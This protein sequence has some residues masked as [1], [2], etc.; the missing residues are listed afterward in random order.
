M[1]PFAHAGRRHSSSLI[2]AKNAVV[3]QK[4]PA[5]RLSRDTGFL[6]SA[7]AGGVAAAAATVTFHPVD[8]MKTVLQG[9]AGLAAVRALGAKGLYRGV[10]PAAFSMMPA[11]A[12]RM[13]A[14]EVLKGVML[15]HAPGAVP[16]SVS[17]FLA[18]ACS[19]VASVSVRAPLDMIKTKVQSDAT[20]TAM[21]AFR[22]AWGSGGLSG[23]ASLYRGAGLA[24][25]RDVPFFGV[26][27][28]VYEQLKASA[29]ARARAQAAAGCAAGCAGGGRSCSSCARDTARDTAPSRPA[30]AAAT[31]RGGGCMPAADVTL[32]PVDLLVI[33]FAAQ[34]LAGLLTN[35]AD[36]LKTRVQSGAASDMG[37]AVR[38]VWAERGPAS[39]MQ[40]AG[41]RVV[42]IAPQG[43]VYYPAYEFVQRLLAPK[44]S[45]LKAP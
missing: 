40:G 24:L 35:P 33:G 23:F 29:L 18:S 25:V 32:S 19:V 22:A 1:M 6:R 38:A 34:G 16:P 41:M 28:L 37:A 26:N 4:P 3:E 17:V 30:K 11:C 5:Q 44:P 20:V 31:P 39:L 13:G 10:L 45:E 42:W 14:Y 36:V 8:T 21:A 12:V 9:G 2:A 43:C 15:D 27:L 7:A